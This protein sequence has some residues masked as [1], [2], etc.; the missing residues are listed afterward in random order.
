MGFHKKKG[1]D[2]RN[3]FGYNARTARRRRAKRAGR[4]GFFRRKYG[5]GDGRRACRRGAAN[6]HHPANR[7]GAAAEFPAASHGSDDARCGEK[8]FGGH[9]RSPRPRAAARDRT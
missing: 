1:K 9:R 8:R 5:N 4:R 3:V 2:S 6:A 7:R